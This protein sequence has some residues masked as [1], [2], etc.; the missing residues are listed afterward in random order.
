MS[1]L[2][3]IHA[4]LPPELSS[5]QEVE[6]D[7]DSEFQSDSGDDNYTFES[8]DDGFESGHVDH[9]SDVSHTVLVPPDVHI[10]TSSD[11]SVS[12]VYA[13]SEEALLSQDSTLVDL[14]LDDH[15]I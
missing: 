13:E 8:G 3:Q 7:G 4:Q 2:A 14:T 11:E 12:I 5:I 10:D 1:V 6:Y 15:T 9:T